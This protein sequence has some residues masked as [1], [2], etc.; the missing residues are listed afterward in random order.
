MISLRKGGFAAFRSVCADPDEFA[1]SIE[2]ASES[3]FPTF[4]V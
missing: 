3:E 2:I 1:S 4:E